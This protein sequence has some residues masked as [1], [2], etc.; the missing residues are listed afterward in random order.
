MEAYQWY[1]WGNGITEVVSMGGINGVRKYQW[2]QTRLVVNNHIL[3]RG[4]VYV[5]HAEEKLSSKYIDTQ[6]VK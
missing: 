1:Q 4:R 2:G 6:E 5:I 3:E